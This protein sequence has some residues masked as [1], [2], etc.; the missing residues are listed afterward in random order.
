MENQSTGKAGR[1]NELKSDLGDEAL[2]QLKDI[3][4]GALIEYAVGGGASI[5]TFLWG[6]LKSRIDKLRQ[7]ALEDI[8]DKYGDKRIF[9]IGQQVMA[10][11]LYTPK[12]CWGFVHKVGGTLWVQNVSVTKDDGL[13]FVVF[14]HPD[15]KFQVNKKDALQVY[16]GSVVCSVDDNKPQ[17]RALDD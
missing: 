17:M 4:L 5:I 15:S 12:Q 6:I 8:R 16:R 11:D 10:A 7:F 2:K 1:D 14:W 13:A 3:G 9:L